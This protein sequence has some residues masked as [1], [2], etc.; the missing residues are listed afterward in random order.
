MTWIWPQEVIPNNSMVVTLRIFVLSNFRGVWEKKTKKSEKFWVWNLWEILVLSQ[1]LNFWP[2]GGWQIMGLYTAKYCGQQ[3]LAM[4]DRDFMQKQF[5]WIKEPKY[6]FHPVLY[7][8]KLN[9]QPG[10]RRVPL[11][12]DFRYKFRFVTSQTNWGYDTSYN[13]KKQNA[14]WIKQGALISTKLSRYYVMMTSSWSNYYVI[15][16]KGIELNWTTF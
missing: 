2:T 12:G 3:G 15:I 8:V 9:D 13:Y 1:N 16:Y 10:V 11:T 14:K 5:D 6:R 7:D 4:Y